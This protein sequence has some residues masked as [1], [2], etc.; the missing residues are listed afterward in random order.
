MKNIF[1]I[2]GYGGNGKENWFPWLKEKLEKNNYNVIVPVFPTPEGQSLESWKKIF[3]K[4]KK[5]VNEDTE[6]VGH[7]AGCLL[8]MKLMENIK[9]KNIYLASIFDRAL[10]IEGYAD[11]DEKNSSFYDNGIGYEKIRKNCKSI[12]TY[13]SKNDPYIPFEHQME[14]SNSLNAKK[15]IFDNAG[16]FNEA[17]GCLE[18]EKLLNDILEMNN[19]KTN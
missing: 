14:V 17:A 19:G 3:E 16:H 11:I 12:K 7:S 15:T 6:Y 18:F 4:Y 13:L 5:Y 10:H 9:A 1:L 2:H 8:I